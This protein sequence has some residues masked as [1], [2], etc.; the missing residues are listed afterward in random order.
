M[1]GQRGE[2]VMRRQNDIPQFPDFRIAKSAFTLVELLVVIAII[3]ILIA[4]LLPAVQAAREAARRMQCSNNLKQ[5]GLAM[6]N[7]ESQNGSFPPGV[8]LKYEWPYFLHHLWPFMEQQSYYDALKG[9]TFDI[10]V[11]WK[12]PGTW[13][14]IINGL[15]QPM[16]LCPSDGMGGNFG[17]DGVTYWLPKTNYLGIFSGLNLYEG[18]FCPDT[19]QLAVFRYDKGI[20]ISDIKDGTSNTMAVVEY[21]KGIDSPPDVRGDF[22]TTRA[23]TQLLFVTLGPNSASPDVEIEYFCPFSGTHNQPLANLPCTQGTDDASYAS[24]RS[25]HP[26]GV[27]AVF[28]D[29]S[30][31]FI[32]DGIATTPWRSLGWIA[33][34]KTI[35]ID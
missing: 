19:S 28:C 10:V 20:P 23:G 21:L 3:G 34:G 12:S 1:S 6:H 22:W 33:D 11:P 2:D 29:G 14:S 9:P 35:S 8:N 24:P 7:F 27:H 17:G 31:R 18:R 16:L 25:R 26:G 32:Q 15:A 5:I 13:P 30:V 4:L